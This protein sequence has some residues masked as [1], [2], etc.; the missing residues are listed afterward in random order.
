MGL[1]SRAPIGVASLATSPEGGRN[2]GAVVINSYALPDEALRARR[3]SRRESEFPLP[4]GE[5]PSESEG[6]EGLVQSWETTSVPAPS[7]PAPL[8]PASPAV[9]SPHFVGGLTREAS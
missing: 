8:P 9:L 5:V 4:P 2:G 7:A 6:G 1:D 3:P